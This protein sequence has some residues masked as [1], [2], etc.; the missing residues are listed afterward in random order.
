VFAGGAEFDLWPALFGEAQ[1][2]VGRGQMGEFAGSVAR[3]ARLVAARSVRTW[4]MRM[5]RR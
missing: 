1:I 5:P 2:D 4:R 3:E